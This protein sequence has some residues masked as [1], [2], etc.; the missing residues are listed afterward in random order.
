MSVVDRAPALGAATG[1]PISTYLFEL[2]ERVGAMKGGEVATYI[3][4]LATVD[5]A[6]FGICLTTAD[7]AVYEAGDTRVP[8]T[9]QS[10]SK[11]LTYGIALEQFGDDVVRTRVGVEPS[12]DAFNEISLAPV[13]GAPVNPMINAG[14]IACAAL[15]GEG[16]A[17]PFGAIVDAY[18]A[19]AG[20]ELVLDEAVYLSER[21][22]G[23]RNRAIVH[24]LRN[25]DVVAGDPEG[26]VDLYFRQCAVSVTCRDLAAIAATLANGGL[27]PLTGVRA[28][29]EDVVRGVL[30]V[31][32][33][34][35]MYDWAGEWLV[36]VGLPAKSGVSG[37]V[38]AVLPGRL[39][40]GVYSPRLDQHGN[41]VRGITV[42]RELSRDLAL[43]LITPGQRLAPAIRSAST[44]AERRSKRVR[45]PDERRVIAAAAE[46]TA[47]F[48]LQGELGFTA[49]EAV[50]RAL[51]ECLPSPELVILDLR[52]VT[53]IDRGG[54]HFVTA[55]AS[56]LEQHGGQLVLSHAELLESAAEFSRFG[57]LDAALEWCENELLK[58]LGVSQA[59]DEV[60]LDEHELLRELQPDELGRLVP[61][62]GVLAVP[63]GSLLVRRGE[64]AAGIFLVT[65]GTLSVV[66]GVEG[67]PIMRLA[68]VS[69][70]MTVGEVAY[71]ASGSRSA[72]VRADSDVECFTLPYATLDALARDDPVLHGKLLH[73]LIRIVVSRLLAADSAIAE[74]AR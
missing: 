30:S 60:R 49:A 19:Y 59:V 27:N 37:G 39:G 65:R 8:F 22:T 66:A 57:D 54:A 13:T 3:P 1:S 26:A 55:L 38:L 12:G 45:H 56:Y 9:I 34:C 7:G 14:A 61:S 72:D 62:L 35:G 28:V 53:R 10:M 70:G 71:V 50:S 42:C 63:A 47:V 24:L 29:R 44:I 64:P 32:T 58:R 11:P 15:V 74:L 21:E 69:A 20:R 25:F 33:T 41:S 16:S 40:I 48:E 23:H 4:E 18:S 46:R 73:G 52:R 6:L 68:T 67:G 5:P 31:M 36:S 43:H 2:L 51:T 17:D